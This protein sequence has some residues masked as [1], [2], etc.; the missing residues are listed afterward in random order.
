M[1]PNHISTF[2]G[3]VGS[4]VSFL[5]YI[6]ASVTDVAALQY[7]SLLI[8][9]VTGILTAVLLTLSIAQKIKNW[10]RPPREEKN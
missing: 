5:S 2:Q 1:N 6:V 3:F 4:C 7:A 10:N 8:G 9:I